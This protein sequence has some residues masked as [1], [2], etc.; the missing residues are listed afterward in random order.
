MSTRTFTLDVTAAQTGHPAWLD[1]PTFLPGT[2]KAI[3]T[4]SIA[5]IATNID[6]P[7]RFNPMAITCWSGGALLPNV[8]THGTY[9]VGMGGGH[10]AYFGNGL[11]GFDIATATWFE[12]KANTK[13]YGDIPAPGNQYGEYDGTPN[14]IIPNHWYF[15]I[16]VNEEDKD[17]ILPTGLCR[18]AEVPGYGQVPYGHAY[19]FTD[20]AWRRLPIIPDANTYGGWTAYNNYSAQTFYDPTRKLTWYW[21]PDY[22][23]KTNSSYRWVNSFGGSASP[24]AGGMWTYS[25]AGGWT[26]KVNFPGGL[27]LP[28]ARFGSG[29]FGVCVDP[30]RDVALLYQAPYLHFL[31][32][33]NPNIGQITNRT[34]IEPGHLIS[35]LWAIQP[36]GTPPTRLGRAACNWSTKRNG[37]LLWDYSA[38]SSGPHGDV[39][40]LTYN[41][42]TNPQDIVLNSNQATNLSYVWSKINTGSTAP[43]PNLAFPNGTKNIVALYNGEVPPNYNPDT[44][45]MPYNR[46]RLMRFADGEEVLIYTHEV[47]TAGKVWAFR[48]P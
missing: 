26:N 35:D 12:I 32:L 44:S 18:E 43:D 19:S 21:N 13:S 22:T 42:P 37:M 9:I 30:I 27:A 11:Y 48:V 25:R 15:Q 31:K 3:G 40:C 36:A 2:W 8:G 23:N 5:S 46:V 10:S 4:N 7:N 47:A 33:S 6:D 34:D 29:T 39:Y 17:F 38:N 1:D 28:R 16:G 20:N 41:G 45:Y 14:K 24:Y